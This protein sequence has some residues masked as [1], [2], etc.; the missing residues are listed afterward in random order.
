MTGGPG[1]VGGREGRPGQLRLG[2]G[3][4]LSGREASGLPGREASGRTGPEAG[5]E[6]RGGAGRGG[7]VADPVTR[8]AEG[9]TGRF[10]GRAGDE[11]GREARGC[12]GHR[13]S[14][15]ADRRIGSGTAG[16]ADGRGTAGCAGRAGH[17]ADRIIPGS[18]GSSGHGTGWAGGHPEVIVHAGAQRETVP[19][20]GYHGRRTG[21]AAV[22]PRGL[23]SVVVPPVVA[24]PGRE[25]ASRPGVAASLVRRRGHESPPRHRRRFK[26]RSI[27]RV[28]SRL[29]R[30]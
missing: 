17:G 27:S 2:S 7:R 16:N 5:R 20:V 21:D 11:A 12:A 4:V 19:G 28:A 9:V 1:P 8:R 26:A 6:P 14:G 29:A 22:V 18:S 15:D 25:G 10:R 24:W 3:A 13:T 30:S 23:R